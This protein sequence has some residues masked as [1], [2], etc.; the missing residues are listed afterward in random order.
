MYLCVIACHYPNPIQMWII[1]WK[2]LY[3]LSYV[4]E[5]SLQKYLIS[6]SLRLNQFPQNNDFTH[7][8]SEII[9]IVKTQF[10][11]LLFEL[12]YNP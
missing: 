4:V 6:F 11:V 1:L 8:N 2:L 3:I 12:S 9:I 10:V 7:L 5:M